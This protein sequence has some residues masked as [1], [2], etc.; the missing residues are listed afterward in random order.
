MKNGGIRRG[1]D[2]SL[3]KYKIIYSNIGKNINERWIQ[4][5]YLTHIDAGGSRISHKIY[6]KS[7]C[8]DLS[9][10]T[11]FLNNLKYTRYRHRRLYEEIRNLSEFK[12]LICTEFTTIQNFEKKWFFLSIFSR[13]L[14]NNWKCNKL[15]KVTGIVFN[16]FIKKNR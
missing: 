5:V 6:S 11:Q 3:V 15:L 2:K 4:I 7:R 8:Y 13:K 1:R 12:F 10:L 9:S 16:K 14:W